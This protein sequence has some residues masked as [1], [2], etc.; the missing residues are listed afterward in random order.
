MGGEGGEGAAG[1]NLRAGDEDAVAQG[2]APGAGRVGR[3]QRTYIGS[4]G[5][6]PI[7]SYLE[8]GAHMRGIRGAIVVYFVVMGM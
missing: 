7:K 1:L 8:R 2:E 4:T 6:I 3:A 5:E